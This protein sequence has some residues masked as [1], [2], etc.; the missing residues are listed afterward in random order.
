MIVD[1]LRPQDRDAWTALWRGYLDFYRASLPAATYE[2]TW[3]RILGG[4]PIHGLALRP[5][6]GEAPI[7]IVHYLF[8]AS[9][10]TEAEIC[11]LQDLFVAVDRRGAGGGRAL[12]AAVAE[13]ARRRS[14]AR[15]YW[16]TQESNA[17][18]RIL[19]DKV[20]TYTGFIRYDYA[21]A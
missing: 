20:A 10:W 21:P 5:R 14:C 16:T 18:A 12:I 15:L 1:E 11:Y 17:T 13:V 6:A 2:A 7:G 9:A 3:R 4:G 19:Y 8:H